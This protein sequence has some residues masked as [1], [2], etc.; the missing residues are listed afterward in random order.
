MSLAQYRKITKSNYEV[1]PHA[2]E[3]EIP[4]EEE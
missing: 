3:E 2:P 4:V 1:P